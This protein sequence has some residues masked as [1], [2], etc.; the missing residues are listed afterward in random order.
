MRTKIVLVILVAVCSVCAQDENPKKRPALHNHHYDLNGDVPFWVNKIGPY[1]NPTETYEYYSL[2]FCAPDKIVRPPQNM[3]RRVTGDRAANS[4]YKLPFRTPVQSTPLCKRALS[5]EDVGKFKK[6]I[7]EYYF[8]EMT[9]DELPIRGFVGTIDV[10]SRNSQEIK[11]YYLFKHLHYHV[12]FNGDQV[13]YVN[14]TADPHKLQELNDEGVPEVEFTYSL[15]WEETAH[16]FSKR[17]ELFTDAALGRGL[18]IHWLSI[19]N[20]FVLVLLL[21]GFLAI[22]IMRIL[23]SDYSRY[24]RAEDEEDDQEDYGWK[25]IHGEVFRF[26]SHKSL[27]TAFIGLGCQG[28][29]IL[30]GVMALAL[31]GF[32]APNNEG[33][34]YTAC[35]MLYAITSGVGGFVSATYYRQFEGD[36]WAWNLVLVATLFTGPFCLVF[37]FV[38]TVALVEHV[39]ASVP[40]GTIV[41]VLCILL[42]VGFPLT[43][44]GGIAGKRTAGDFKAPCRTKNFPRQIPPVPFYRALPFQML[45]SGFLPFS[46][47]YIELFYIYS[48]V[49]GHSSYQLF[50]ILTIVFVILLIVTA[51][52]T[53]ALTYFQ[54][55]MEDYRWW[56]NS[57]LTGGATGLFIYAYSIFYY[58]WRSNMTGFLQATFYF[59]YMAVVCYFF[60]V[61]LATVGFL[62]S[63]TF[64]KRIYL[65]LK[66]D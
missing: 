35:I 46:A 8:F 41:V 25:L 15:S 36:K 34:M 40:I 23:K 13:I 12:L 22:I 9:Y 50:G 4:L 28:L 20:S 63:L 27:F 58:V 47:I 59:A 61:M 57:W 16:P 11:H 30:V 45:M 51:C 43:L 24:A 31:T 37:A 53:V 66:T 3:G 49:W 29:A 32:F 62:S 21:T 2:P 48:A 10:E 60:F 1:S 54:L 19:M 42:F 56:W 39:T 17:M 65:N 18:E 44:I 7:D 6:A 38:N 33:S 55:S 14:V 5:K 26:P 52:I 64:V